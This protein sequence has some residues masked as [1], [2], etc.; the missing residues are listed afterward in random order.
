LI[1][2]KFQA[3]LSIVFKFLA[4]VLS[5]FENIN[6][7]MEVKSAMR[8]KNCCS[9]CG[10]VHR[11]QLQPEKLAQVSQKF[12]SSQIRNTLDGAV[13]RGMFFVDP[14][15]PLLRAVSGRWIQIR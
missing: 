11:Y 8:Q 14:P 2:Q 5:N 9:C 10:W 4:F 7:E 6:L 3:W 15:P 13:N 1:K 12:I